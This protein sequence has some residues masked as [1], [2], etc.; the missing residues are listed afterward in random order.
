MYRISDQVQARVI[1]G[2]KALGLPPDEEARVGWEINPVLMATAPGATPQL[3]FVVGISVPVPST[4]DDFILHLEPLADAH[5]GQ[6]TVSELV[7]KLYA[8]A[9]AEAR[10]ARVRIATMANGER[11]TEGGLVLP[12]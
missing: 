7:A 4:A 9:S 2:I 8:S 6:E 3:G 12:E 11:R 10:E 1:E 5:A